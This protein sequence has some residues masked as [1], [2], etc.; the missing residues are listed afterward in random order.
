MTPDERLDQLW[1]ILNDNN[2]SH[3][4]RVGEAC[5]VLRETK[6]DPNENLTTGQP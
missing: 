6:N 3:S 1:D 5:K 4:A 2:L